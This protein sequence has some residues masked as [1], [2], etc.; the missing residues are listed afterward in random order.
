MALRIGISG[1]SY[2]HWRG[3]FYP[4][5]LPRSNELA[6]VT[7]Y[8]ETIEIN[9]SFYSLLKADTYRSWAA[10]GNDV[11]FAVRASRYITHVKRLGDV[12]TAMA[13][14]FA[15]GVGEL[16]DRLGPVLWQLPANFRWDEARVGRFLEMLPSDTREMARLARRHDHRVST[17]EAQGTGRSPVRHAL[18]ARHPSF[19]DGEALAMFRRHDIAL[20]VSHSSMWP[21]MDEITTDFM[22]I[23][24]HG[25]GDLYSSAYS[26]AEL[27]DWGDRVRRWSDMVDDIYVYFDN[28]GFAHAPHQALKF[29]SL[30]A[31]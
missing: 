10:T 6:F 28:D 17:P 14:F 31:G 25:P 30:V 12:E 29:A 4:E 9:R 11:V 20:V 1:W 16:G 15:S 22:Y 13:N 19:L 2:D 7:E 26:A 18:E 8:F 5:G 3:H 21:C 24:L 27:R 23:R